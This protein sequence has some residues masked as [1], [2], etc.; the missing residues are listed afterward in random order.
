MP[1]HWLSP[2][3]MSY[4]SPLLRNSLSVVLR[5]SPAQD[6]FTT[7]TGVPVAF[8]YSLPSSARASAGCQSAQRMRMVLSLEA[9]GPPPELL[10]QPRLPSK[11]N[12]STATAVRERFMECPPSFRRADDP[13]PSPILMGEGGGEGSSASVRTSSVRQNPHPNPLPEYRERG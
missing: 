13:T 2:M 7:T 4:L 9:L 3:M 1:I 5:K 6:F 8:S 10:S 12:D 11:R